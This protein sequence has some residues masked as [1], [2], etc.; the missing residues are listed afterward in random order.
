MSWSALAGAVGPVLSYVGQRET[1]DM[2][3]EMFN[4]S[5]QFNQAA[6]KEQMA[7]QERMSNTAMQRMVKDYKKAGINPLLGLAGGGASSPAGASAS[8]ASPPTMENPFQGAIASAQEA[9]RL[10]LAVKKQKEE[11][12]LLRAQKGKTNM[13]TKVMSK[14]LP[15]ADMKNS[16]YDHFKAIL[17]K[18][19]QALMPTSKSSEQL[20]REHNQEQI[21]QFNKL[22]RKP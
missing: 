17:P 2:N 18:L 6:A 21:N 1:N 16:I 8:A 5:N 12:E 11:V 19:N 3:R 15:E 20:K 22:M 10:S 4:E 13:E 9:Y 14:G 7:F